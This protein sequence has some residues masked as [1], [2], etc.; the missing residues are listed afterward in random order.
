MDDGDFR[1][2][3]KEVEKQE[4]FSDHEH[5]HPDGFFQQGMTLEKLIGNSYIF[6]IAGM[7]IGDLN[8]NRQALIDS[9]SHNTYFLW[10]ERGLKKAHRS[11]VDLT[12]DSW[13]QWS[14]RIQEAY[15]RDPD[16]H[17]KILQENRYRHFVLDTYW[18]PGGDNGHPGFFL[19]TFRIDKLMY[20]HHPQAYAPECGPVF[21]EAQRNIY[22]WKHY[23]FAGRNLDDYVEMAR[24][25]VKDLYLSGKIV[26]LKCT[27]AYNR[28]I[29]FSPDDRSIAEQAF[30][31]HPGEI[32]AGQLTCFGN[33][34]FHR[35]CE[36]AQ[37]H[38]I[39]FQIHTGLARLSGSDPMLLEP[40]LA[41]YP[42]VRFILFHSGYPWT[43]QAA[44]LSHNYPNAFP[45]LT[46]TPLIS[47]HVA[48]DV[49]N[50]FLDVAPSVNTITWGSDSWTSEESVGAQLAWKY[51]VARALSQRY[52]D[53]FLKGRDVGG[54]IR[55]L[56]FDNGCN[57]YLKSK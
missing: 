20:G 57:V 5:H 39:P 17:L 10:F 8:R 44:A 18:D 14:G 30:G 36:V 34:L 32:S 53:G 7:E 49:L 11:D 47:T 48:V 28:S 50:E 55:K 56:M 15:A 12:A 6:W 29:D 23:R 31:R 37:Q 3:Y 43:S 33:Y 22:P 38:D 52:R 4:V 27:I 46:W 24:E 41:R 1:A 45:S 13:A 54:L 9:V 26:A 51:V 35:M 16:L 19:P 25:R 21:D 2:I 42:K 40:V